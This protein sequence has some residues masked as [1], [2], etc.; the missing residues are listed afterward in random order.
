MENLLNVRH[1]VTISAVFIFYTNYSKVLPLIKVSLDV[2]F[3][4]SG[5][6]TVSK[7][8]QK[9]F[10]LVSYTNNKTGDIFMNFWVKDILFMNL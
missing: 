9:I 2:R 3:S 6:A 5:N 10:V 4:D 8:F 1:A 7:T